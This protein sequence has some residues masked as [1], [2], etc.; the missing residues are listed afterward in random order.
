MLQ[1]P[2]TFISTAVVG[3]LRTGDLGQAAISGVSSYLFHVNE[4]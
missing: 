3:F 4:E 1:V 2:T